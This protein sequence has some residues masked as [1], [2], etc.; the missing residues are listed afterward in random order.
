[1]YDTIY[2]W[3]QILIAAASHGP[4]LLVFGIGLLMVFRLSPSHLRSLALAGLTIV[5][6]C[7]LLRA[8]TQAVLP[9]IMQ[10]HSASSMAVYATVASAIMVIS[11]LLE[12]LGYGLLLVALVRA[13]RQLHAPVS[14]AQ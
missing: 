5:F 3:T 7:I 14:S 2:W 10:G 9:G 8:I 13:L 12:A 4:S 6:G 11:A 1:M